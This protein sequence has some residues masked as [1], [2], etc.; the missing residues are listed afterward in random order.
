M[1][2]DTTDYP[3]P[4]GST[5]ASVGDLALTLA[6][7]M[8]D[9]TN[10]E[11][12]LEL[13]GRLEDILYTLRYAIAEVDKAIIRLHPWD[14]THDA[15]G[16]SLPILIPGGGTGKIGGG[17]TAKRYDIPMLESALAAAIKARLGWRAVVMADGDMHENID[18]MVAPI[19]HAA[20]DAAGAD[21]PSFTNYRS[22][23]LKKYGINL[24]QYAT[25]TDAA[26]LTFRIEGRNKEGL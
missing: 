5:E 9:V 20:I 21:A 18:D 1:T 14:E 15:D 2:T 12:V 7:L 25:E 6:G 10:K 24:K 3:D 13:R 22:G 16:S 17:K 19:V 4:L 8:G 26:P 23:V 11:S